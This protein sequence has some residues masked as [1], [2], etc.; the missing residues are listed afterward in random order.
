MNTDLILWE[1]DYIDSIFWRQVKLEK[2]KKKTPTA[3]F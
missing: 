2:E 3:I 1:V